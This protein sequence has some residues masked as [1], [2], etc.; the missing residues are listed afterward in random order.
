MSK[1]S[2]VRQSLLSENL[3]RKSVF[4]RDRPCAFIDK[5]MVHFD[6]KAKN[7]YTNC[8]KLHFGFILNSEKVLSMSK[9]LKWTQ[10]VCSLAALVGI[11]FGDLHWWA[12]TLVAFYAIAI[13][14]GA[15]SLHR[16]ISHGSFET[17]PIRKAFLYFM[18]ILPL[19]GSPVGWAAIHM[20]HHAVS[21]EPEDPH[22][23][24]HKSFWKILKS[25]WYKDITLAGKYVRR[26]IKD[27]WLAFI[28]RHYFKIFFT[29]LAILFVIHPLAPVFVQIIPAF[30]VRFFMSLNLIVYHK[31]G[32]RNF[33][34]K[35]RSRNAWIMFPI[36]LGEALHN[37]HH[38]D[39]NNWNYKFKTW[40]FDLQGLIIRLVFRPFSKNVAGVID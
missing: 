15:I 22:S 4:S 25:D 1:T 7:I 10:T 39:P 3:L 21:D 17:G 35:D 27:P 36:S 38:H 11:Y 26:L 19:V 32:Y 16:K 23:P 28:H 31:W 30:F 2:G 40:E 20:H 8:I 12:I 18:A 37:N 9:K 13:F 14:G 34:T 29:Y 6:S 24:H 5:I 33:S